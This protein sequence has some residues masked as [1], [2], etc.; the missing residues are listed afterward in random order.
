M[1]K[2]LFVCSL[3]I[4]C[5]SANAQFTRYRSAPDVA[6]RT[7][8]VPSLGY[9][10]PFTHYEPAYGTTYQQQ[11][12][13]R[14][15]MQEVTLRGYYKNGNDWYYTPIRV[16]VA[17]EEVKLLSIKSQHGWMNCGSTATEV[18]G[19]ESEEIRDNFNYKA[20]SSL[21]GTVYF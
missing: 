21:Y 18:G 8:Q 4:G 11:Q 12:P 2:I 19:W 16:G 6:P 17:G 7:P 10:V 1:K 14:P 3:L 20:Y 9:G 5:V 13:A 15:R